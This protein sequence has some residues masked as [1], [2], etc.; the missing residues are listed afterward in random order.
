MLGGITGCALAKN[1]WLA[2]YQK[3]TKQLVNIRCER[4]LLYTWLLLEEKNIAVAEFFEI[5]G[6]QKIA[7][8][9]MN[10]IARRFFD[11]LQR[12]DR[13]ISIE[14]GVEAENLGAV[15]ETLTVYRLKDDPLPPVD[16]IVICDLKQVQKKRRLVQREF[17]GE[18]VTLNQVMVWLLKQHHIEPRD[19]AVSGW[20]FD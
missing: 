6:F 20:P 18:V 19:G 14:Y 10:P 3:Q 13:T 2:K 12:A 5:H 8:M 4:D 9:G 16:C 15:H 1:L 7:I 17:S 11:A